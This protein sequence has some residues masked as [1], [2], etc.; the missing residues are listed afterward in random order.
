MRLLK[1]L[2]EKGIGMDMMILFMVIF[3]IFLIIIVALTYKAG[4]L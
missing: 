2:N 1:K 3:V 4:A